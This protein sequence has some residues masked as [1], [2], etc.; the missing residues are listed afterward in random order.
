[1]SDRPPDTRRAGRLAVQA[2]KSA[3]RAEDDAGATFQQ[4]KMKQENGFAEAGGGSLQAVRA[5]LEQRQQEAVAAQT[6]VLTRMRLKELERSG[7]DPGTGAAGPAPLPGRTS[8]AS[9][10]AS[11]VRPATSALPVGS[12]PRPWC[13]GGGTGA[14]PPHAAGGACAVGV[15]RESLAPSPT[16]EPARGRPGMARRQSTRSPATSATPEPA[17]PI[18]ASCPGWKGRSVVAS[19]GMQPPAG[20]ASVDAAWNGALGSWT[21]VAQL[22]AEP[23][24]PDDGVVHGHGRVEVLSRPEPGTPGSQGTP[25]ALPQV[26]ETLRLRCACL[27]QALQQAAESLISA[28][29]ELPPGVQNV[30]TALGMVLPVA[31]VEESPPAPRTQPSAPAKPQARRKV[32]LSERAAF[33]SPLER[34]ASASPSQRL[35][36]ATPSPTAAGARAGATIR[37]CAPSERRRGPSHVKS[38][39]RSVRGARSDPHSAARLATLAGCARVAAVA[40]LVEAKRARARYAQRAG[41][42]QGA[43]LPPAGPRAQPLGGLRAAEMPGAPSA[44]RGAVPVLSWAGIKASAPRVQQ[45]RSPLHGW[46]VYAL[47][48][49][50]PERFIMEYVGELI[51]NR[52]ADLRETLYDQDGTGTMYLFR[53]DATQVVDATRVGGQARYINHSCDPNCYTKVQMGPDGRKHITIVAK[54]HIPRGSELCYDYLMELEPEGEAM[55]CHC[56]AKNCRGR[57]N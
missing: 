49:I 29:L 52:M 50:E 18:A 41:L 54:T 2:L 1:M 51:G 37:P 44:K 9:G 22:S 25:E 30:V 13:M 20:P 35:A 10:P 8:S 24:P 17:M 55:P 34:L 45:R 5:Q 21:T 43:S 3:R 57:M 38:A 32:A 53:L 40:G 16:E 23:R 11:S 46:G 12:K 19:T 36:S 26:L 14:V 6:A 47:E 42:A 39:A 56:G 33:A 31:P 27:A 28:G 15:D 7:L 48:D 4:M